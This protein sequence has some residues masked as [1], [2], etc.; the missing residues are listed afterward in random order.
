[1]A[2]PISRL[3][4]FFFSLGER[5]IVH[6]S[7][8]TLISL[9]HDY[10]SH[11]QSIKHVL[12]DRIFLS[13]PGVPRDWVWP[14]SSAPLNSW[15]TSDLFTKILLLRLWTALAPFSPPIRGQ[16]SGH[17]ITLDQ[18][19]GSGQPRLPSPRPQCGYHTNEVQT[20]NANTNQSQI[21]PLKSLLIDTL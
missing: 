7:F 2:W 9:L 16:Y 21:N 11:P 15:G 8:T 18:W 14:C 12:S 10:W 5:K 17:V 1:M 19:E 4:F 13:D 3:D 6:I 20:H